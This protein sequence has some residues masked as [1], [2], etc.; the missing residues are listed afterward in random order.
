LE[1]E[2]LNERYSILSTHS[3][4][5]EISWQ[6]IIEWRESRPKVEALHLKVGQAPDWMKEKIAQLLTEAGFQLVRGDANKFVTVQLDSI[7]EFMKVDGFE[8]YTFTLGISSFVNGGKRGSISV[9]ES[10]VGR[11]QADAL[12]KVKKFFNDHIEHHLADL[13]LD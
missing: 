6:K 9:S 13:R 12:L 3:I 5:P 10:V 8:K 7:I 11:T 4:P 2:R 1:R